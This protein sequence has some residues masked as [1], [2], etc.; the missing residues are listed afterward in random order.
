M[1]DL[2]DRI[3]RQLLP[4]VQQPSQ[5]VGGEVNAARKDWE[6]AHLR[7]C[8]AFPDTYTI[9]VSHHGSA[10]LYEILNARPG[11][12]CD[13][14]YL[15]WTDAQQRMRDSG[16]PLWSWQVRRPVREF[17]LLGIS[18]QY[19]LLYTGALNLL[20]LTGLPLRSADR[21]DS[22]PLVIAGGAGCNNPEPMA[23]FIDLF[24]LGDGEEALPAVLDAF[25]EMRGTEP[26]LPRG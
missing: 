14:T 4:F 2:A 11:W 1:T 16:L 25:E 7:F 13:R 3:S 5:Y 21:A 23:P 17:D 19:E 20:D 8:L 15:P 9:G 18:L 22:D 6:A 10:V 12:L 24:L 26:R